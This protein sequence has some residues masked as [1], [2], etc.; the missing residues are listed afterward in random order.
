MDFT[1]KSWEYRRLASPL[2]L[3]LA[4][5]LCCVSAGCFA[6]ESDNL[7]RQQHPEWATPLAL[8]GVP[9]LHK[10][11]EELYRGAQPTAE[12]MQALQ[13][14]GIKTIVSFRSIHSDRDEI[15][16]LDLAYERIPMAAL[17]PSESYVVRFLK[18]VTD[19]ERTPVF[20][21]CLHGA[22][23]TGVMSAVYRIMIQDWTK[24]AAI[25]EM[26]EGGFGYHSI[27]RNLIEFLEDLDVEKIRKEV[28]IEAEK[29]PTSQ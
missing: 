29:P 1:L 5:C 15:G 10:V 11:S 18:I 7:L 19:P 25:Q 6:N 8:E 21:H 4:L 3:A 28:G 14:F 17:A 23:R 9:N 20:I 12:G 24:E 22:D 16:D 26:T 2:L 13:A 27:F